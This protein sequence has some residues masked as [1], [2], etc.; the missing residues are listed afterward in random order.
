M[1]ASNNDTANKT[2]VAAISIL[3]SGS[4]ALAKLAVGIAITGAVE[5]SLV[6]KE[7]FSIQR[8][9]IHPACRSGGNT[10]RG[11]VAPPSARGI[12][13]ERGRLMVVMLHNTDIPDGWER[14]GE[15]PE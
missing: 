11:V 10:D 4:L 2:S 5:P 8:G 9:K 15:D 6:A 1:G 3:A 12:A 13:D 14:E 7:D